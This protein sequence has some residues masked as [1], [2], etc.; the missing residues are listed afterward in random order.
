[1]AGEDWRFSFGVDRHLNEQNS[2]IHYYKFKVMESYDS[3]MDLRRM[4]KSQIIIIFAIIEK[5]GL[6]L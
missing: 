6:R 1:M 4:D 3:I 5:A 2:N